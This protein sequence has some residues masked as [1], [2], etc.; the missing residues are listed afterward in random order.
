[1]VVMLK[2]VVTLAVMVG[3]D[4]CDAQKPHCEKCKK[5]KLVSTLLPLTIVF[6]LFEASWPPR[7]PAL[8]G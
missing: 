7:K 4:D 1:M 5:S 8:P 3:T 6:S 2:V